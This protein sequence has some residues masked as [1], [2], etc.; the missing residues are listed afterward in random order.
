MALPK[1]W[2][3]LV[4]TWLKTDGNVWIDA[5]S[6]IFGLVAAPSSDFY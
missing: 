3:A 1:N 5:V 6:V 4:F 2:M